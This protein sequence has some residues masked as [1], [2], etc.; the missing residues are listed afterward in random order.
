[1]TLTAEK[2]LVILLIISVMIMVSFSMF[3]CDNACAETGQLTHG[4]VAVLARSVP[5]TGWSFPDCLWMRFSRTLSAVMSSSQWR[6]TG[7]TTQFN[8][9]SA[10]I[11]SECQDT[12]PN[13]FAW[14]TGPGRSLLL[15]LPQLVHHWC[16]TPTQSHK[17]RSHGLQQLHGPACASCHL[18]C[19]SEGQCLVDVCHHRR[20]MINND[21]TLLELKALYWLEVEIII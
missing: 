7:D 9:I 2:C 18:L 17:P 10:Y 21:L 8:I 3:W 5:E 1:M 20:S 11:G 4:T 15:T 13:Q 12:E 19:A 14:H 16:K 6:D